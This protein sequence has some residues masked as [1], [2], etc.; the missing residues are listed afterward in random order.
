MDRGNIV[1]VFKSKK[2][3]DFKNKSLEFPEW[4]SGNES[5]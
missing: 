5:D 3:V 1:A 4:R 2:R